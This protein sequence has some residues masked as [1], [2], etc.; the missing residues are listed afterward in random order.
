VHEVMH[1]QKR[2]PLSYLDIILQVVGIPDI[3]THTYFGDDHLR[4]LGVA[5]GQ[6]FPFPI[7]FRRRPYITLALPCE[8]DT[9]L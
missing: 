7:G 4:V 9:L 2:T 6:I 1:V 3:I 5:G 8:C